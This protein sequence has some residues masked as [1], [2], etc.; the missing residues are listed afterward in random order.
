MFKNI[1]HTYV[2][3]WKAH[4][5]EELIIQVISIL[6]I[7]LIGTLA[8]RILG[9]KSISQMTLTDVL[10]V[11]VL[12]S[13]LGALITKPQ[14]TLV[15]LLV[16]TTIV[17]FVWSLEKLALKINVFERIIISLPEIIYQDGE[18]KEKALRKNNLTVDN[19]ESHVRQ[20]GYPSLEVCKTIALEP[21]G[22]ISFELKPEY[23]PIKKI[24]FDAAMQQILQAINKTDYKEPTL[25]DFTNAFEEITQGGKAH[26]RPVPKYLE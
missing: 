18:F 2:T 4:T 14:R 17:L 16:V 11:F 8:I 12:S 10:F 13:T 23:E 15:A 1:W 26:K 21:T 20:K 6:F 7:L 9:K 22:I 25:P 3:D 19:I 24:Y 5:K